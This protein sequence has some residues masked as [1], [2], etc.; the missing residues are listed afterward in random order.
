MIITGKKVNG[1]KAEG[2]AIV[3]E[4]PFSFLG[5]LDPTTGKVPTSGH[6]L[7]G[8]SIAKKVL[9]F[10]TGRGS[11]AGPHIAYVAKGLG[12]APVAIIC[13]EAEPVMAMV[14]IMNDIPMV[15]QLNLNPLEVI[16]TGDYVKVDG[17]SATVEVI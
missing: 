15:H 8:K 9:I 2:E 3:S 7:E 14:A 17:D 16:K 4:W 11:T 1:G 10:P 5:D 13:I 6:D 12:N